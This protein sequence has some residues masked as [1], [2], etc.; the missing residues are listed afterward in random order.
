MKINGKKAAKV[1][2]WSISSTQTPLVTTTLEQ[3]DQT[4][5][6]GLRSMTG[7]CRLFYY[8]DDHDNN[9]TTPIK[10]SAKDLVHKLIKERTT[11]NAFG[12]A[13]EPESVRLKLFTEDHFIEVDVYVTSA[14]M[15][16]AVGEVLSAEIAFQ[17]DGAPRKGM[18]L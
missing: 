1:T 8:D 4:Y 2:N 12:I 7:S 11:N 15:T 5:I 18:T 14:S 16:M 10:N 17:V 3:T 13:A 9:P 6:P